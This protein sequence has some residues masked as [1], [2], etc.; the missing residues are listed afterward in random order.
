[1]NSG[2][3]FKRVEREKVDTQGRCHVLTSRG[4]KIKK[5]RDNVGS[6]GVFRRWHY[7]PGVPRPLKVSHSRSW[8][9]TIVHEYIT[10]Y[11]TQ[12]IFRVAYTT[13]KKTSKPLNHRYV[14]T[15]LRRERT[16]KEESLRRF[17]KTTTVAADVTSRGREAVPE[18]ATC[19]EK[20]RSPT[21]ASR[22]RR[23]TNSEDEDDRRQRRLESATR[24]NSLTRMALLS[25]KRVHDTRWSARFDVANALV[26]DYDEI[27]EALEN[28]QM[29]KWTTIQSRHASRSQRLHDRLQCLETGII[30][31][32]WQKILSRFQANFEFSWS[33]HEFYRC[34]VRLD[35]D[36]RSE[37]AR[38]VR[39]VWGARQGYVT[40]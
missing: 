32:F 23:I 12:K 16:W 31:A 5:F 38:S 33:K 18:T 11:I 34:D 4:S 13:V 10:L 9:A 19:D 28:I 29:T 20:A 17:R 22:V 1:M 6:N 7:V 39:L 3:L 15:E 35:G 25:L 14:W 2:Q 8:L 26:K 24:W 36:V 30:A 21:V 37:S 40:L 27:S